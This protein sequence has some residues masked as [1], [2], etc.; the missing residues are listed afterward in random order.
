MTYP[1][2]HLNATLLPDGA[3]LVTGGTSAAGFSDPSGSVRVAEMWNPAT[4]EWSTLASNRVDRVYHST[5]LLLPD[6]RVLH[7]GSGDGPGLSRE[8]NAELFSPP[9]LFRGSR[10]VLADVPPTL[11]YGDSFFV[12]TPDGPRVVRVTL[13]RLPS[14]THAFDQSQRFLELEFQRAAGGLTVEAP[15]SSFVAP[16]GP[17]LLTLLNSAGVP[18][19]SRIVRIL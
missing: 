2:R 4:E 13:I 19:V 9:Y 11:G 12:G 7:A 10:P 8:L 16:P 1:R 6:G 15:P 18:S 14:V 3:V 17:Y 5:T